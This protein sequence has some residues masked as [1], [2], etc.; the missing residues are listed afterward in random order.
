[1]LHL[2]FLPGWPPVG[3]RSGKK[4]LAPDSIAQ[5]ASGEKLGRGFLLALSEKRG[6]LPYKERA[7]ASEDGRI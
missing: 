3:R 6:K 2:R 7:E 5:K 4:I 1:M